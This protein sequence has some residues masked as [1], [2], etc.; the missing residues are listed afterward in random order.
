M[1][2]KVGQQQQH[3]WGSDSTGYQLRSWANLMPLM[4][5][6]LVAVLLL[7]RSIKWKA[8]REVLPMSDSLDNGEGTPA[9]IS[10]AAWPLLS[11]KLIERLRRL[12]RV[13]LVRGLPFPLPPPTPPP[14]NPL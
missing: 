13:T 11:R 9:A 10:G 1:A 2:A 3:L 12:V 4:M 6:V 7:L 8:L 5:A 14:T